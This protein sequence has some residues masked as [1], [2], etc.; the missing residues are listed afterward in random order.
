M[1]EHETPA[2]HT[3]PDEI[4]RVDPIERKRRTPA[5]A[6]GQDNRVHNRALVL[7]TLFHHGP[8][9]RSDL[10]RTSR[11]TR[12]T[13]SALVSDLL[14]EGLVSE[15][16]TRTEQRIGK[17]ATLVR[18]ED[19]SLNVV[20]MDLSRRDEIVGA[21]LNLRGEVIARAQLPLDDAVGQNA[22]G[23]VR[24]L[25]Q[26]L[27]DQAPRPVLGMGIGTP[28]II[29]DEGTVRF[30]SHLQW[31][32]V[33]LADELTRHYG[34]PVFVGNDI[35]MAALGVLHFRELD[36]GD[37]IVLSVANAVGMGVVV[38]DRLVEGEYFAAGEIG[39]LTVDD[40]GGVCRCGRRGCV[41][42]YIG[43]AQSA[44]QS[45]ADASDQSIADALA[46]AGRAIGIMVAPIAAALD[47]STVALVG[48]GDLVTD[49][50]IDAARSTAE[51]RTLPVI[52]T[53]V[54]VVPLVDDD[55]LVLLGATSQVLS[56]ELGVL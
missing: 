3:A 26:T 35:N 20:A 47:I 7:H 40:H 22:L 52:N 48:S 38:N 4:V 12:P 45:A 27:L 8:M 41:E 31:S 39:H 50:F 14:E 42:V 2:G 32:E 33:P 9:S 24:D 21:V 44:A 13:V 56:K 30:G 16:G 11:L 23:L 37:L 25:G 18:L 6:V 10:A 29:D 51:S 34:L 19:D 36:A 43:A 55:D 54:S 28:G 5:K 46:A 49:A 53:S 15:I 1:D 17:P